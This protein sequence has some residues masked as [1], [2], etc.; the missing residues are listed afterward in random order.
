MVTYSAA[1]WGIYEVTLR[2]NQ[3]PTL[4]P[5]SDDPDPTRIGLDQTAPQ[6]MARRVKYPSVRRSW[7]ENRGQADG[8]L[9]GSE[10]FV[11]VSWE[12]ATTL[13]AEELERVRTKHGNTAI[14]GGSYGWASAGRFH[15]AQGQLHRFLN[16]IGGYV[17]HTES[18]SLGAAH[19]IL[20]FVAGSIKDL[21]SCHTTWDVM[22]EHTELFVAFGG[23]PAKN[24]QIA[25]GGVG[26]H[27]V[28][29]GLREMQAKGTRFVNIGPVNDNLDIG[30]TPE[31]IAVR[32]NTDTALMLAIAYVLQTEGL[33]NKDFLASHCTGYSTFKRY[34]L[35]D[36]DGIAKTPAW[37]AAITGVQ[38][39]VIQSLAR[40][41]AKARTM[42]NIAWSLQRAENGEQPFWMMITLAAMLGQIGLPGGGF[43]VGYGA[44]NTMGSPHQ[45]LKGPTLA[46]GDNPVRDYIPVARIADML[47]HPGLPFTHK[48]GEKLTYPDIKLIYWAGGNPYHHHQDLN[49]LNTA[50]AVPETIIVHEQFWTATAQRADIVLPVSTSLERDDIGY[51][52]QEGYLVAMKKAAP[53]FHEARSDY[54]ILSDIAAKLGV[55]NTFCENKSELEWLHILYK[56][57]AR[58]WAEDSIELPSFETFWDKG[59]LPIPAPERSCSMLSAFRRDPLAYPLDTPTGKFEI[60]SKTIAEFGLPDF[61]PHPVWAP[62]FEWLGAPLAQKFPLH[63]LT[64]QPRNKLHSQLDPATFSQNGKSDGRELVY[65]SAADA[66]ARGLQDGDI[67]EVYNDRGVCLA[68]V[69]VSNQIMAGVIRM[70]TGTWY[71]P[72]DSG[73]DRFGNPNVLTQDVGASSLSQ[74]CAAQSCLV[75][76]RKPAPK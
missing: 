24:A 15:H 50:W 26:K 10:E 52:N 17:R 25:Q 66:L 3:Q 45:K 2:P 33:H 38:A 31:W 11:E 61:A 57:C 49:K 71:D 14:F 63:L 65:I 23:V 73:R 64:D 68:T 62:G 72:D 13:C 19:V 30:I 8:R 69:S 6:V 43:G 9:R 5:F 20:P 28:G 46:Q 34:L 39:D 12:T 74:G 75:D 35:G 44:A 55:E 4:A 76:L 48:N 40:D 67:V 41:M 22:A 54:A 53:D 1:H 59:L 29:P 7:L 60:F 58:R 51:A 21:M 32:P 37:A 42:I 70:S 56:G 18:Y 47:L 27:R 16:S 36:T